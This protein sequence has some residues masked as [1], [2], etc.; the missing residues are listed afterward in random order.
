VRLALSRAAK[1]DGISEEAVFDS[2]KEINEVAEVEEERREEIF[3][4]LS[5]E[6]DWFRMSV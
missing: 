1:S 5:E 2:M 4:R 3:S 6:E